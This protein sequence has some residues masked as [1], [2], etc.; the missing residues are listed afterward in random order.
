MQLLSHRGYWKTPQEQNTEIAFK[1]SFELGFGTETDV[2][3]LGGQLVISHDPPSNDVMAFEEFLEIYSPY[4]ELP[5]AINIKADGLQAALQAAMGNRNLQNWFAF[6]MS[7]PDMLVYHRKNLPFYTRASEFEQPPT[8]LEWADG[9]WL[10]AFEA[11][12]FNNS[13]IAEYIA[14]GKN[15]CIVSPELHRRSHQ[16]FWA[17]LK[18]ANFSN[19]VLL[20]TDFPE[21][22]Q[23]F[24][25]GDQHG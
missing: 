23:I 20:C 5:L 2:R 16:D 22:A 21:D 10:D 8:A 6:D 14:K 7:V 25:N 12:W 18:K 4:R 11:Q 13:L 15:V 9:I 17:E 19:E 3:D 1:R 24:F